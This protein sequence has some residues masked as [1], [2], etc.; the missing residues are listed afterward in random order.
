MQLCPIPLWIHNLTKQ[1]NSVFS[2]D[3][4][5]LYYLKR[6]TPI[7]TGK[8]LALV[9]QLMHELVSVIRSNH[10]LYMKETPKRLMSEN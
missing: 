5:L 7:Y 8:R 9:A 3:T 1:L 2:I 10:N 6:T 4:N